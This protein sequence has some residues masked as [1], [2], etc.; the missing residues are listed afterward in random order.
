MVGKGDH[1]ASRPHRMARLLKVPSEISVV[2]L[3]Q[4]QALAAMRHGN[5]SFATCREGARAVTTLVGS[6]LL[7][8]SQITTWALPAPYRGKAAIDGFSTSA[9]GTTST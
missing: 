9:H 4:L 7:H 1:S 2:S 5:R 3:A 8:G 6:I